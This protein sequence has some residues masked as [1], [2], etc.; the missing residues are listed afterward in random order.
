MS[1]LMVDLRFVVAYPLAEIAGGPSGK[2]DSH[3][4]RDYGLR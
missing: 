2:E 1:T 4:G 3:N